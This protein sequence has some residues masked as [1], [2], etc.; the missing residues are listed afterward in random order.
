MTGKF[1]DVPRCSAEDAMAA[2]HLVRSMTGDRLVDE[3]TS[4]HLETPADLAISYAIEFALE[5]E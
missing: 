3:L 1:D 4:R 5:H 2:L